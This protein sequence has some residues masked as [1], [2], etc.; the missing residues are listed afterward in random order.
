MDVWC[1]I[2]I[3]KMTSMEKLSGL[4]ELSDFNICFFHSPHQNYKKQFAT[5]AL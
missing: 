2:I 3:T 4:V 5:K 1:I